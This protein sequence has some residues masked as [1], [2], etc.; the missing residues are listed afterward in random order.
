MCHHRPRFM[1]YL[2]SW[3]V[4]FKPSTAFLGPVC[5]HGYRTIESMLARLYCVSQRRSGMCLLEL[6]DKVIR[7]FNGH[8]IISL[9]DLARMG[10]SFPS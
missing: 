9:V 6:V 5:V 7:G 2:Y 10:F 4:L 8:L 3:P 1:P